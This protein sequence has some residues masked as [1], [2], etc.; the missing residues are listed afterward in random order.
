MGI[1]LWHGYG[2]STMTANNLPA[3]Y[4]LVEGYPS[5]D[6]YLNLRTVCITPKTPEQASGALKSSWYGV[7]VVEEAAVRE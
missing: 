3:G 7:Y 4:A 2:T 5:V 6:D 1:G